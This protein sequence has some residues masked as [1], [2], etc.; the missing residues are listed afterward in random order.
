[1]PK[2]LMVVQSSPAS[3][4]QDAAYN[5]WYDEVHIPEILAIAGFTAARR[6]RLRT[7]GPIPPAAAT[8]GYLTA[9]EVEAD[10]L[11][12]AVDAMRSRPN[13]RSD[14]SVGGAPPVVLF[15]ELRT[16]HPTGA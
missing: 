16:E 13:R 10:D 9:Y 6:Y 15:Y 1:M 8:H 5:T 14:P 4:D 7:D 11:D 3:P 2:G 12:A